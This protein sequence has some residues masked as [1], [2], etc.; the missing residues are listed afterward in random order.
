MKS[1]SSSTLLGYLSIV[2]S[3]I[4]FGIMPLMAN[5]IYAEGVDS[6]SLVF[7]RNLFSLPPLLALALISGRSLKIPVKNLPPIIVLAVFGCAATPLLLFSS[8]NYL[9]SGTATVLH[10]IYPVAVIAIELLVF[11]AS[12][13]W[14]NVL[15]IA[16]CII[17]M[18]LF[19]SPG[20]EL[21]GV[22]SILTISSGITY[23]IYI[24]LLGRFKRKEIDSFVFSFYITLI[25]TISIGIVCIISGEITFP[26][27]LAGWLVCGFF[28]IV[29]NVGAVVLFQRGTFIIG[30]EKAA[31]LSTFE[32]ITSVIVGIVAFGE[33]FGILTVL[34]TLLIIS[35]GVIIAVSDIIAKKKKSPMPEIK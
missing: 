3:A 26:K 14:A 22:G 10:F 12:V 19:Y 35:A 17:G 13:R 33:T 5:F 32:P 1:S 23:A 28:A 30:G 20:G 21:N 18:L 9:E 11:R 16:L 34:G 2:A 6:V 8:Y 27:T 29:V 7:F 24:C 25:A 4:I 15:S 31:I